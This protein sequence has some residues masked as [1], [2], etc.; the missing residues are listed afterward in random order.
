MPRI[1]NQMV[2]YRATVLDRTFAA[3]A[4]PTRRAILSRLARGDALVTEL[5]SPFRMSIQAV[6]K[7]L[8]VL[9]SAGLLVRHKDGRTRRCRLTPAPLRDA[10][11]WIAEYREFWHAQFEALERFLQEPAEDEAG[12]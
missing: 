8:G 7:H 3:L 9:E 6:S 10:G 1:I 2:E 11:A 4:D 12:S 5:A